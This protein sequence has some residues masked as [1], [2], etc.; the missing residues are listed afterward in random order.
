[1]HLVEKYFYLEHFLQAMVSYIENRRHL[2]SDHESPF[3]RPKNTFLSRKFSK[4]LRLKGKG[5]F[6]VFDFFNSLVGNPFCHGCRKVI[7][8]VFFHVR[9]DGAD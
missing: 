1:M 7:L 3:R 4:E 9:V 5:F 2:G 6:F 8:G